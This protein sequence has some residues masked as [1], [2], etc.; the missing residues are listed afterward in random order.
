MADGPKEEPEETEEGGGED[1]EAEAKV[2]FKPLIEVP[3]PPAATCPPPPAP[4]FAALRRAPPCERALA[5]RC[6]AEGGALSAF[7]RSC[8]T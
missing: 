4:S 1:V 8:Q 7:A 6:G 2:E 3:T 5:S